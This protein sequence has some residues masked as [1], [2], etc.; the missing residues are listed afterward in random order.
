MNRLLMRALINC[1]L[2]LELSDDE[3]V[4][5][6]AA[7]EV[8]EYAAYLLQQLG[9]DERRELV[10]FAHELADEAADVDPSSTVVPWLRSFSEG[11]GL[12][13]EAV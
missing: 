7:V 8:M 9:P 4:D 1:L 12:N 3:V 5:P 2:F 6:D 11:F 10:Q 13:D